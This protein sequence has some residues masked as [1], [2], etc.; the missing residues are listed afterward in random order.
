MHVEI[1]FQISLLN[2][3]YLG[4]TERPAQELEKLLAEQTTIENR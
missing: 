3:L 2:L 4:E 1:E